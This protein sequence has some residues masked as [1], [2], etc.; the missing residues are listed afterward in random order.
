M[1]LMLVEAGKGEGEYGRYL[2]V[3]DSSSSS[4]DDRISCEFPTRLSENRTISMLLDDRMVLEVVEEVEV[5]AS[6]VA[7]EVVAAPSWC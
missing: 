3:Q 1:L 7:V 2:R 4:M 6:V 5:V